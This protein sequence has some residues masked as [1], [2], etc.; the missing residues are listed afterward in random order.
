MRIAGR[1]TRKKQAEIEVLKA[2]LVSQQ[3]APFASRWKKTSNT[4]GISP[5]SSA[6]LCPIDDPD[7]CLPGFDLER[8]GSHG[9]TR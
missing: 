9:T 4:P 8:P 3:V 6:G 5:P 7:G 1:M 2:R